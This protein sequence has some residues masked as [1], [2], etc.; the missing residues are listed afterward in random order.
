MSRFARCSGLKDR[1]KVMRRRVRTTLK[2]TRITA[3]AASKISWRS[4]RRCRYGARSA[5]CLVISVCTAENDDAPRRVKKN[6]V[7]GDYYSFFCYKK[8]YFFPPFP[9]FS[10]PLFPHFFAEIPTLNG[11]KAKRSTIL[12]PEF[13]YAV[14]FLDFILKCTDTMGA[15]TVALGPPGPRKKSEKV[16]NSGKKR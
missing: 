3:L 15:A 6:V 13:E 12:K 8:V 11:P 9:P 5:V 7:F 16:Q 10:V 1:P 2:N 14:T 4:A